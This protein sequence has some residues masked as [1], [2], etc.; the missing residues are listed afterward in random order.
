MHVCIYICHGCKYITRHIYMSACMCAR[1]LYTINHD[2]S[3]YVCLLI[4]SVSFWYLVSF[5]II[6]DHANYG[7]KS[8]KMALRI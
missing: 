6:R 1:V 8:L 3:V 5:L 4:V 2:D 7:P